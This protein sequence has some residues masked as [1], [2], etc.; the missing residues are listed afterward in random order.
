MADN[1]F[2][3]QMTGGHDCKLDVECY[4]INKYEL[5]RVVLEIFP[6]HY[7]FGNGNHTFY[8]IYSVSGRNTRCMYH[9]Y[10]I[11]EADVAPYRKETS[12]S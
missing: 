1:L 3:I 9:L 6:D 4:I 12:E 11:A 8:R 10:I 5:E 7:H 2:Y